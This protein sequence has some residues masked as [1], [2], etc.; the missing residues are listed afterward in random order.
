MSSNLA[1]SIEANYIKIRFNKADN[2]QE[3]NYVQ[4]AMI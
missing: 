4:R 3:S 1:F 2:A